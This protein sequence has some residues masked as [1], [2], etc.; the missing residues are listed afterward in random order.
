[1][2]GAVLDRLVSPEP[3]PLF[4]ASANLDHIHHFGR[5]SKL[6]GTLNDAPGDWIVLLD[7]MPLV[8]MARH[9]TGAVCEQLAGSELLPDLLAAAAAV[10]CRIG[11]L[12]GM[13]ATH[14]ALARVLSQRFPTL[15]VA[16]FWAPS[17]FEIE[18]PVSAAALARQVRDAGVDMLVVALG[19]P[20]Q[21]QWLVEHA[22]ASTVKVGLAFGAAIDFLAGTVRR[23]PE[24]WRNIG[25]EWLFRLFLEPRRL[26]R[27][28][29]LHGPCAA[30]ALL[31]RS[32]QERSEIAG[33]DSGAQRPKWH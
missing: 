31:T 19:K 3:Q 10:D 23:A 18:D 21:E 14:D 1:M 7:G 11:V 17:R 16:G 2:I 12:G 30:Y 5:G 8:W 27:R 4:L 33:K 6:Q 20:R 22:A 29:L 15:Q 9:V 32:S 26:A 13:Q 24:W 28:Y 25:M